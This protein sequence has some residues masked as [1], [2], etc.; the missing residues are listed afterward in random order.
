[1]PKQFYCRLRGQR[2]TLCAGREWQGANLAGWDQYGDTPLHVA[3][4]KGQREAVRCMVNLGAA[5]DV[6]DEHVRLCRSR[7]LGWGFNTTCQHLCI[8][9]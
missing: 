4:G 3:V 6:L 8:L 5:V 7:Q 2:L 1:L 9:N